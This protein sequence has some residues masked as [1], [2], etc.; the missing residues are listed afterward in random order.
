MTACSRDGIP[1]YYGRLAV[2]RTKKIYA[3][4]ISVYNMDDY[5]I[6][7]VNYSASSN[8]SDYIW[9]NSHTKE[10][11]QD[12]YL[13]NGDDTLYAG[14]IQKC[15]ILKSGSSYYFSTVD[16]TENRYPLC[17]YIKGNN[18]SSFLKFNNNIQ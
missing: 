1:G 15:G 7:L 5:W 14:R 11:I 3:A 12:L 17:E 16:C 18:F 8:P 13:I 2:L 4:V 9:Y 10:K 6:G